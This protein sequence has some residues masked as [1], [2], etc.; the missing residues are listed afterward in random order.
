MW[1]CPLQAFYADEGLKIV[2]FQ[3]NLAPLFLNDCR[4]FFFGAELYFL[5]CTSC[6]FKLQIV[7]VTNLLL[8]ILPWHKPFQMQNVSN[9]SEQKICRQI[10]LWP[11]LEE[12]KY[13]GTKFV[14]RDYK[15]SKNVLLSKIHTSNLHKITKLRTM[16]VNLTHK[17]HLIFFYNFQTFQLDLIVFQET[18]V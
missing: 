18:R 13:D 6:F 4:I 15:L 10:F 14:P 3:Q 1:I 11:H 9:R 17:T 12:A 16:V 7:L 5:L 8:Q 2:S